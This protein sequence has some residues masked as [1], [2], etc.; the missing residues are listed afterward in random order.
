MVFLL[1]MKCRLCLCFQLQ[2]IKLILRFSKLFTTVFI[3]YS[4]NELLL[5]HF[6]KL[7]TLKNH[8]V[9]KKEDIFSFILK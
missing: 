1:A 3:Y 6:I 7:G 9:Q 4:F 2:W 5:L 8:N